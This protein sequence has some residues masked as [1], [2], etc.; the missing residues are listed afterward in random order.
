MILGS[1][2]WNTRG[3]MIMSTFLDGVD[4]ADTKVLPFVTYAVTGMSGIDDEYREVLPNSDVRDGLT[5]QGERVAESSRDLDE[6][7]NVNDLT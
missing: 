7:L 3:P 1:P 4:L 6:W 5:I 2:V